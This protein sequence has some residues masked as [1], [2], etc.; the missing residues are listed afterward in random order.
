MFPVELHHRSQ[1]DVGL[2]GDHDSQHLVAGTPLR[3]G[4]TPSEQHS[5][6]H[7]HVVADVDVIDVIDVIVVDVVMVVADNVEVFR[8]QMTILPQ[9]I[10]IQTNLHH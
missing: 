6:W 7:P 2:H 9:K 10:K 1:L 8:M 5:P 3:M 4:E